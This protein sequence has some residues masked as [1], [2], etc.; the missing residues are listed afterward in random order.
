MSS[1]EMFMKVYA[2]D[3]RS[4][5]LREAHAHRQSRASHQPIQLAAAWRNASYLIYRLV[6]GMFAYRK[7]GASY[8][9]G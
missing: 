3:R 9:T 4:A 5:M 1:H 7:S 8:H 2:N 6:G